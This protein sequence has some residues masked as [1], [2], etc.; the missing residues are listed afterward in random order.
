MALQG[1]EDKNDT[2]RW[3]R[4]YIKKKQK[5]NKWSHKNIPHFIIGVAISLLNSF[6]NKEM[7]NGIL[8]SIKEDLLLDK[9]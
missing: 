5:P 9:L 6:K 4:G 8:E 1:L 3:R 7:W 2:M